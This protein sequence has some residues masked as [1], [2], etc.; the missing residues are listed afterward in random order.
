MVQQSYS[1][2]LLSDGCATTY[3]GGFSWIVLYSRVSCKGVS[4][5]VNDGEIV[6]TRLFAA[7]VAM[8]GT[9][10]S[11]DGRKREF[12]TSLLRGRVP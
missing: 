9:L 4:I 5:L 12:N 8:L 1:R 11:W 10:L 2:M 6:L 3:G 7:R